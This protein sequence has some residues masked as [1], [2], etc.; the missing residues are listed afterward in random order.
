MRFYSRWLL[1][2]SFIVLCIPT[3]STLAQVG[4]REDSRPFV[5]FGIAGGRD[6]NRLYY[7]PD[8]PNYARM[9]SILDTIV[10]VYN[11]ITGQPWT[12]QVIVVWMGTDGAGA[13]VIGRYLDS[14]TAYVTRRENPTGLDPQV[15]YL[16]VFSTWED[17][18]Y[19]E[20]TVARQVFH[21]LQIFTGAATFDDFHDRSK[22]W[23]VLGIA[24]WA[25]SRAFPAQYPKVVHSEFDQRR[26][27]TTGRL[28]SFYFWEFMSSG[29]GLGSD[30]AVINQMI[31]LYN[32]DS[33]PLNT[34][35]E[36]TDLFHNWALTLLNNELPIP[37]T[38]DLTSSDVS[39]GESGSIQPSLPRFAADYKN[40][41]GFDVKPG[42]IG[43]VKVSGLAAGNYAVSV[44][45]ATGY[46][47]LTEGTPY[48]L[49]PAD[50]GTMV[51]IS[52]GK[53][54]PGENVSLTLEWGQEPSSNPCKAKPAEEG[55]TSNCI[56]GSWTVFE[57]PPSLFALQEGNLD[58]SQFSF[59]FNDDG[60]LSGV[61]EI[62][63]VSG[64]MGIDVNVNFSGTYA[65]S[66]TADGI[67][68]VVDDFDWAF[69]P[70]G[71]M[72]VTQQGK[73]TDMTTAFYNNGEMSGWAPDGEMI[74][75][76]DTLSWSTTDGSGGFA[77][78]RAN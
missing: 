31:Q 52:R 9:V 45:S 73:Q 66:A 28:D 54:T 71:S 3:F 76:G 75:D 21:C 53:G 18:P 58:T 5:R 13:S 23:W 70:G 64:Q 44:Q 19:I 61:Y 56:V 69:E 63:F 7:T 6:D 65:V 29:R 4:D 34:I 32:M 1:V 12:M 48:Q 60:T 78:D 30:Q 25:A 22:I 46:D 62:H 26:D 42:N 55:T 14:A 59:E 72:I 43:Y 36:P 47:R 77:L 35:H 51:I 8:V 24:E 10:P 17:D 39:A 16:R 33:F 11:K 37:P 50:T 15:C 67:T 38:V 74:C 27:V 40:L 20:S 49:C 2:F 57:F 68:Y 41:V